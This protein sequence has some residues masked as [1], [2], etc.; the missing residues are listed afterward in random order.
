M[1]KYIEKVL[2]FFIIILVIDFAYGCV[3]D[4]M[5]SHL[6]GGSSKRI[7]DLCMTEKHDIIILGSSRARHH[8]IPQILEDSL[9][10]ECY[11]GGVDGHGII[12]MNGIVELMTQRYTPKLII[13]DIE[14][15]FDINVYQSDNNCLRYIK[16]LRPYFRNEKISDIIGSISK[17]E[18][19]YVHSGFYRYNSIGISVLKD[20]LFSDVEGS[21]KGYSPLYGCQINETQPVSSNEN[22]V[23]DSVKYNCFTRFVDNMQEKGIPLIV[24]ASPKY[25]KDFSDLFPLV[26]YCKSQ[27]ITFLNYYNHEHFMN[28]CSLFK[29]SMHLNDSGAIVFSKKVASD[30]T[31]LNVLK[32]SSTIK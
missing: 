25:K 8:Y 11:N 18:Y 2:L 3:F 17:K 19:I 21:T 30:L 32:A 15:A 27:N 31:S 23:V 5:S 24:V 9:N 28:N 16:P 20:F 22:I 4:Y 13:Y 6:K 10:L 7:Y 26:E 12:L 14:N 1:K 29:E